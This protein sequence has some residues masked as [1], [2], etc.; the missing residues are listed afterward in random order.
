MRNSLP[1]FYVDVF[2]NLRPSP[3]TLQ[4]YH[5]GR[6]GVS[7]HQPHDCLLNRL[8]RCRSK[9]TSKLRITGL[10]AEKSPMTI[11]FSLICIWI[12]DWVNNREAG[13]LR[14]HFAH[15][16]IIVMIMFNISHLHITTIKSRE[17]DKL[18]N[19]SV[20]HPV[21]ILASASFDTWSI[22]KADIK[23]L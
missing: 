5:N 1:M 8:S 7:N 11:M 10:C 14:R 12:N 6:D 22:Y 20:R 3:I 2:P 21:D 15:C 16:D 23:L 13:D 9:K 17:H 18:K 4:W 19:P